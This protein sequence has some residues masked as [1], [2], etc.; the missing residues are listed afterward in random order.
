MLVLDSQSRSIDPFGEIE[1]LQS[2]L[3]VTC[4]YDTFQLLPHFSRLSEL[5]KALET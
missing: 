5:Y 4:L 3:E 1:P 2:G